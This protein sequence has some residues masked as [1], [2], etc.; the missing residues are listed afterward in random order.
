MHD[1]AFEVVIPNS[2]PVDI[3]EFVADFSNLKKIYP[4]M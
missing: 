4:N 1:V 2:K 3:W